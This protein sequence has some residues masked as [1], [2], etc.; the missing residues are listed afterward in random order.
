M[1]TIKDK[2]VITFPPE[3]ILAVN[4]IVREADRRQALEYLGRL[5]KKADAYLEPK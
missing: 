2:V 3:E 4:K 5:N 1:T